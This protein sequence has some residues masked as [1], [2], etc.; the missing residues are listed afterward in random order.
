MPEWEPI[1]WSFRELTKLGEFLAAYRPEDAEA[2]RE[3]LGTPVLDF[4]P[5]RKDYVAS[6]DAGGLPRSFV[7]RLQS[8]WHR[9]A[10]LSRVY[11]EIAREWFLPTF[12]SH[13]LTEEL[14]PA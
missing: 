14:D 13:L 7:L 12:L 5:L 3:Y 6:L 4:E 1:G 8:I 11:E 10:N 9:L 2:M